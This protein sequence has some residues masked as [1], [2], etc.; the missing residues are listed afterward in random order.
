MSRTATNMITKNI[1]RH[2]WHFPK[3]LVLAAIQ[4]NGLLSSREAFEEARNPILRREDPPQEFLTAE[5]YKD[6]FKDLFPGMPDK[7]IGHV[8]NHA[9]QQV[10]S[11]T[12]QSQ[13]TKEY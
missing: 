5:N 13:S 4:T 3:D 1:Y 10:S 9:F 2:G 7:D 11:I 6:L 8:I 12:F